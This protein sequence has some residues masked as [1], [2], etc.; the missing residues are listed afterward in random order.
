MAT[1]GSSI[2]EAAKAAGLS[3]KTIRYYEQIGL[4][5]KAPRHD[6][7]ARTGGN[8]FYGEEEI[9]RL[10][11]IHHAR[12][13]DLSLDDIRQLL[14]VVE[15]NGCPGGGPE[16]HLILAR[17]LEQIDKRLGH[18]RGLRNQIEAL[19]EQNRPPA[20]I[21]CSWDTCNCLHPGGASAK[22]EGKAGNDFQRDG[23]DP[24]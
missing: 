21:E 7:F 19:M 22:A 24:M 13:L 12:M 5:P 20:P 4:V 2:G 8:R 16:Y 23:K 15:E 6:R 9:G 10:K 1:N 11:F 17:H 18:L 3:V 14:G